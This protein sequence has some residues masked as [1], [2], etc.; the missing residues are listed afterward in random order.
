MSLENNPSYQRH[1]EL[2]NA[3]NPQSI[4]PATPIPA[5]VRSRVKPLTARE[6]Q[7]SRDAYTMRIRGNY[8]VARFF[9]YTCII[10]FT[11]GIGFFFLPRE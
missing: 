8:Q 2:V 1:M 5:P 4:Y 6:R 11:G 10:L 3:R 9:L 7:Y